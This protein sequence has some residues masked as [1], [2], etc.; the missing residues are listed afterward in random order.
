MGGKAVTVQVLLAAWATG[1]FHAASHSA[2]ILLILFISILCFQP[3]RELTKS[4]LRPK[5]QIQWL[6][7]FRKETHKSWVSP[8]GHVLLAVEE[9]IMIS[10]I[11]TVPFKDN[12][13]AIG[14]PSHSYVYLHILSALC[15]KEMHSCLQICWVPFISVYVHYQA[16]LKSCT[17]RYF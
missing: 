16:F 4:Q 10:S 5:T 11:A 6:G 13:L 8:L 17:S 14:G 15:R 1:N 3:F 2:K 9:V 7:L 12:T